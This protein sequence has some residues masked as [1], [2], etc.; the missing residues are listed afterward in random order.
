MALV[1]AMGGVALTTFLAICTTEKL[2]LGAL[3]G[4]FVRQTG[5]G[6]G[7]FTRIAVNFD[8]WMPLLWPD[9]QGRLPTRTSFESTDMTDPFDKN[10]Q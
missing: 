10:L 3:A 8:C 1:G 7:R 2:L 5:Q 6:P 9:P 4:F